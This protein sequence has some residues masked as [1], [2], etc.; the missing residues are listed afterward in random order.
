LETLDY[1]VFFLE[2]RAILR[3]ENENSNDN[4]FF[5]FIFSIYLIYYR[6]DRGDRGDIGDIGDIGDRE[7]TGFLATLT[8]CDF[9]YNSC[10]P[11]TTSSTL[12]NYVK[13]TCLET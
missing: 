8:L 3:K 7:V 12:G 5:L 4:L 2:T 10:H 6:G 13:N 1:R 11:V 9:C